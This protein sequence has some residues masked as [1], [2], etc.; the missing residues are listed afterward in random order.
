M[1][2]ALSRPALVPSAWLA[3]SADSTAGPAR[4]GASSGFL[5]FAA[6]AGAVALAASKMAAVSAETFLETDPKIMT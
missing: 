2:H 1:H 3:V 6:K 5:S 4:E